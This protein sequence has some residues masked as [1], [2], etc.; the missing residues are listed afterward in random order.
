MRCLVTSGEY[1]AMVDGSSPRQAALD[2]LSLW[3]YKT[4]K[5]ELSK[6][7]TA[8]DVNGQETFWLTSVLMKEVALQFPWS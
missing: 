6:I 8:T 3:S 4:D 1:A 7:V 2:A 5:P